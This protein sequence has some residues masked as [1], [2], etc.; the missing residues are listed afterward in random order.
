MA[1]R[2]YKPARSAMQSGNARTK[3]WVLEYEPQAP[4]EIDPLMGWATSSDPQSQVRLWFKT[5]EE[6]IAFAMRNGVPFT[7][8]EPPPGK[9][10][11]KSYADN[12]KF[13][14]NWV[15]TH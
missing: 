10:V 9:T 1:A 2:I 6:A 11:R 13:G 7:V 14:R 3:E 4:T 12:F 5:K 15:W 8:T